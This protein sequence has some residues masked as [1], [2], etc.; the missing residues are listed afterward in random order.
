MKKRYPMQ[1][2]V[3]RPA[4]VEDVPAIIQ[5]NHDGILSWGKEFQPVLQEW[6][7]SVCNTAYFTDLISSPEKTLLIAECGGNICGTAY[8]YPAEGRF[9]TGGMYLSVR[10]RGIATLLMSELTVQARELGFRELLSTIHEN[11]YGALRF[12]SRM[13]WVHKNSEMF[14]GIN[15]YNKVLVLS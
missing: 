5:L 7:D 2:T 8:G 14:D 3:I 9:Y 13:G 1:S 11:N 4:I 15:Y 10:G 6:I 12:F